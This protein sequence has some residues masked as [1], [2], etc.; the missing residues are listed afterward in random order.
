LQQL[1]AEEEGSMQ[2]VLQPYT[3][4]PLSPSAS[5]HSEM[6]AM[7][8]L[9]LLAPVNLLYM[10]TVILGTPRAAYLVPLPFSIP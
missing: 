10:Y 4:L 3:R 7:A 2:P 1:S 9:A 6:L 5:V 8:M